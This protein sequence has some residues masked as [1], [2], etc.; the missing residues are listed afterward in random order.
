M[1]I[2]LISNSSLPIHQKLSFPQQPKISL[3]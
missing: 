1:E 3:R 2:V